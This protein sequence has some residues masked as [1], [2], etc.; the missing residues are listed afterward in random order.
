[1][2]TRI[3]VWHRCYSF[4]SNREI[5]GCNHLEN[6]EEMIDIKLLR[7]RPDV[8]KEGARRKGLKVDIDR[9][10][11][12]DRSLHDLKIGIDDLRAERNKI[13]PQ[14]DFP[15]RDY[16]TLMEE[17][18]LVDLRRGAKIGGFRQYVLKNEAVLLEIALLRWSIEFLVQR[19]FTL[20]R[21]TIT[22]KGDALVSTGWFPRGEK[23]TYKV[24]DGLFLAGTTEVPLMAYHA[25]PKSVQRNPLRFLSPRFS[26][27]TPQYSLQ[28][29]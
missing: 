11:Q 27:E 6:S 2:P 22:V 29:R 21:P 28:N 20:L 18:D 3:Y 7:E 25:E 1:M 16:I 24:D 12:L 10:L 8:F 17:L 19:G 9:V 4:Q 14:F 15:C 5:P 23:D 13:V 26:G